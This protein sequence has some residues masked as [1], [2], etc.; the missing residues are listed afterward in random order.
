MVNAAV[1]TAFSSLCDCPDLEP[2][3]LLPDTSDFASQVEME[4]S[5]APDTWCSLMTDYSSV[6]CFDAAKVEART[7]FNLNTQLLQN[8]AESERQ[9]GAEIAQLRS[10]CGALLRD[11]EQLKLS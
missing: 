1:D 11:K 9:A 8:M 10:D 2:F 3:R 7:F 5:T 4:T 6:D